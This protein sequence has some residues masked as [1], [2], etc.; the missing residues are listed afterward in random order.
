MFP[1]WAI[2]W[3][4][5]AWALP[6]RWVSAWQERKHFSVGTELSKRDWSDFCSWLQRKNRGSWGSSMITGS[7]LIPNKTFSLSWSVLCALTGSLEILEIEPRIF[8]M[9]S[10]CSATQPFFVCFL[11]WGNVFYSLVLSASWCSLCIFAMKNHTNCC[12]YLMF[13]LSEWKVHPA[14]VFL[15]I[16]RETVWCSG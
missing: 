4:A 10:R 1:R 3:Q 7:C 5:G 15:D 14:V 6:A 11:L 8:C 2:F 9:Q 16:L 13:L 12:K